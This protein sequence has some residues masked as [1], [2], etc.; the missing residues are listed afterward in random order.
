M[1]TATTERSVVDVLRAAREQISDP[2]WWIKD[3]YARDRYGNSVQPDDPAATCFCSIGALCNVQGL[4]PDEG[5]SLENP[6]LAMLCKAAG[7]NSI[8]TINDAGTH[9]GVLALFHRAIELAEAEQ[10]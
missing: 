9:K 1:T 8:A 7:S 2:K 4:S 10:S 6:A 5:D 3:D